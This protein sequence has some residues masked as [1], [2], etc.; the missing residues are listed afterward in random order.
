MNSSKVGFG[1]CGFDSSITAV[2][3]KHE[4][5]RPTEVH[6]I[7]KIHPQN[8]NSSPKIP[9]GKAA[10]IK[11][12][13][14]TKKTLDELK[15][16]PFRAKPVPRSHYNEPY[17]PEL[18]SK[19]NRQPK[20]A[21]KK[22]DTA[23]PGLASR[24]RNKMVD[25][26][27]HPNDKVEDTGIAQEKPDVEKVITAEPPLSPEAGHMPLIDDAPEKVD[28]IP[29][30]A[31]PGLVSRVWHS[32]V[33]PILHP[34][35]P[36]DEKLLEKQPDG[37]ETEVVEDSIELNVDPQIPKV[38]EMITPEIAQTQ[39]ESDEI[40]AETDDGASV[41]VESSALIPE[42]VIE[43]PVLKDVTGTRK[44]KRRHEKRRYSDSYLA[45]LVEEFT[46][47]KGP[48]K[49]EEPIAQPGLLKR[50]V[51]GIGSTALGAGKSLISGAKYV[52][53]MGGTKA[54]EVPQE[55]DKKAVR[56]KKS[57]RRRAGDKE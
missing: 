13:P 56:K 15:P 30:S 1:Y 36:H 38:D 9:T 45:K 7:K 46:E 5:I 23:H 42:A 49:P 35:K 17:R 22:V 19:K 29:E 50:A 37:E 2:I 31:H 44:K 53:G 52:V 54:P 18:P 16:K 41:N 25:P 21:A 32:V 34:N 20:I 4:I 51:F 26:I 33:D 43:T 14:G 27:L 57:H 3:P 55:P 48:E 11:P 47:T 39:P 12:L 28:V 40:P 6:R 10:V 24:I 8:W